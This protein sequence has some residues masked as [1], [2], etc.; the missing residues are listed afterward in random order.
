MKKSCKS[1]YKDLT[2]K[3]TNGQRQKLIAS[4]YF[5]FVKSEAKINFERFEGTQFVDYEFDLDGVKLIVSK[6]GE[7]SFESEEV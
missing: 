5:L 7:I 3:L 6:N 4:L 2:T 1:K